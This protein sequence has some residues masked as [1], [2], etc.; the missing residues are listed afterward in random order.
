MIGL[1]RMARVTPIAGRRLAE[2][3]VQVRY[4]VAVVL[5]ANGSFNREI[6]LTAAQYN[7]LGQPGAGAPPGVNAGERWYAIGKN[8]DLGDVEPRGDGGATL[9]T[10]KAVV[11]GRTI[12]TYLT[13]AGGEFTGPLQSMT[14][15]QNVLNTVASDKRPLSVVDGIV[16]I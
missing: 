12:E 13:L 14:I 16:V 7:A 6:A 2:K 4:G 10:K 1:S 11:G 5:N 15:A 8:L 3:A 9:M